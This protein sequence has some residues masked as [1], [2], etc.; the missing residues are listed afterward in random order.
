MEEIKPI[1]IDDI[2]NLNNYIDVLEKIKVYVCSSACGKSYLCEHDERFF[3]LDKY[4]VNLEEQNIENFNELTNQKLLELVKNNSVVLNA[5]RP[6]FLDFLYNNNIPY[7]QMYAKPE[8]QEEYKERMLNRGS[9]KE[10]AEQFSSMISEHYPYSVND[11]RATIKIE[12]SK[13]EYASDYLFRIFGE[14]QYQSNTIQQKETDQNNIIQTKT[15]YEQK[16]YETVENNQLNNQ[17]QQNNNE[18]QNTNISQN[19]VQNNQHSNNNPQH[20]TENNQSTNENI[21]TNSQPQM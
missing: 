5:P 20:N 15:E 7:C 1:I 18:Q 11:P 21:A 9:S 17:N 16:N 2:N 4:R 3:D 12:H 8:C 6:E 14:L 10:F 19:S 13:N